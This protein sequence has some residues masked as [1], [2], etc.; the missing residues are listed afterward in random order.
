MERA[1]HLQRDKIKTDTFQH[2]QALRRRRA[3]A[4]AS[5]GVVS[6]P[7]WWPVVALPLSI[8]LAVSFGRGS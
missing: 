7:S 1:E 5:K 3:Q 2:H 4:A 8:A 6:K